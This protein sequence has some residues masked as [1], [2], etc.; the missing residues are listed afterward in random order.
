MKTKQVYSEALTAKERTQL[1]DMKELL[2]DAEWVV[3]RVGGGSHGGFLDTS[4][5]YIW[6]AHVRRMKENGQPL[7]LTLL[8]RNLTHEQ[9][10]QFVELSREERDE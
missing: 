5:A 6:D 4:K 1:E 9:A 8:A 7:S 3:Y 10:K 2:I